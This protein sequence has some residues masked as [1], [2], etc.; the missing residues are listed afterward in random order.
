MAPST[1]LCR[2]GLTGILS[3]A[4]CASL[5]L[6][7]ENFLPNSE[8]SYSSLQPTR[9]RTPQ[10]LSH[11]S[12]SSAAVFRQMST[13]VWSER[14]SGLSSPNLSHLPHFP[15]TCE[16][17]SNILV[18]PNIQH[19]P[20]PFPPSPLR[21]APSPWN[22]PTLPYPSD[23]PVTGSCNSYVKHI[24]SLSRAHSKGIPSGFP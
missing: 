22:A 12:P 3:Q 7:L 17:L 16:S 23:N 14:G 8:L 5:A 18:I 6:H 19:S 10:P 4:L 2:V 21:S 9:I 1:S 20:H 11:T 24:L 15:S 13:R